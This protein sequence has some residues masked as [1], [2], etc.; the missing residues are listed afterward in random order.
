MTGK[1][2][3]EF[4]CKLGWMFGDIFIPSVIVNILG[5]SSQAPHRV[6]PGMSLKT[7]N[8]VV[9]ERFGC[10]KEVDLA[11]VSSPSLPTTYPSHFL[12]RGSL[13]L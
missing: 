9:T 4:A 6:V 13:S 7:F 11:V 2:E 8:S 3:F 12:M 5:S 1:L 10:Y